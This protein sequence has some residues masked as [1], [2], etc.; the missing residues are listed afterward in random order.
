MKTKPH[1]IKV[2]AY[3]IPGIRRAPGKIKEDDIAEVIACVSEYYG[4][5]EKIMKSVCRKR[6]VVVARMMVMYLLRTWGMSL[7]QIGN[8]F[9][10]D[11]TTTMHACKTISDLVETNPAM[12]RDLVKLTVLARV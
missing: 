3:A 1:D 8:I 10:R 12:E 2:S 9:H 5:S 6:P 4:V 11:H 7:Q